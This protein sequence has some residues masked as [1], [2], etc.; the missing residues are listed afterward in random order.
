MDCAVR[1][2]SIV[3]KV[4][5]CIATFLLSATLSGAALL[6]N[7]TFSYSDGPLVS[8]T[9]SL[10]T[11]Y[12]GTTGQVKVV[13]G[14][15]F[16][17]KAN[18][19]DVH[20]ALAGQPYAST[21]GAILYVSFKI[22]YTNLPSSAGSYFAEFKDDSLGFRARI[23]AQTAGAASG[24]FR[25][26]IANAGSS[27]SAVF[28]ADLQTNTDYTIVARLAVSNVVS[29]LWL[30][31]TAETNA[32]VTATDAT[33]ALTIT[34]FGFREDGSSGTIGNFFVDDLRVGT[35]FPDVVTN[36]PPLERPDIVSSSQNQ[37]VTNGA[38]VTFSVSASGTPPLAYQWQFTPTSDVGA[39]GTNLPGAT[40]SNLTLTAVTFAQAGFYTVVITNV[41][42]FAGSDPV[43][44]SVWFVSPPSFSFLTYNANG[45]GQTNWSTNMWHVRAIG[46]QV[47]YLDPDIITFQEIPVT[48]N[49]TAQMVDF[50][51]AFCPGFY[52]VTNSADDGYIR[53]AILSR[54][55][56]VASKSWLHG[57]YL[58]PY[59]YT[60]ASPSPYFSRDLFEAQIAVP[61][62][63]QPLHVFTV[64]LKSGQAGPESSKRAAEAGAVSNFFATIYLPTNGLQPYVL[65][66]DLN[67]DILWPPDSNPQSI[68]RLVSAPTGL[69]LATPVNPF[70]DSELTISIRDDNGLTKRYDY[71]LPCAMLFSNIVG[72]QVFRT[73]L[74][75]PVPPNLY[76]DDE[77]ASDHLPVFMV[78]ANPFNV[79]FRLLSIG[80]TN[81]VVSLK[82]ESTSNRQYHVEVSSNLTAWTLLVTNL[83]ATGADFTFSTNVPSDVKFFRV[84]RAP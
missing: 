14:R 28:N 79:P 66:G 41:L 37:T 58:G 20:A 51:A 30:N 16:L 53:S 33:S 50:V 21:S 31:P 83:A 82:W 17:S 1:F 2:I 65:S 40:S 22:N 19:E 44:L 4:V 55:P 23:F 74:L 39:Q 71:I 68:Q 78:F 75:Y 72:S 45:N 52:L 60:N 77:N 46:R 32:G 38:S 6:L 59:G 27:P 62:F 12:S 18:T 76:S 49:C 63:P 34:S 48:N 43:V 9:D 24:A 56:I 29:T 10:W 11:T 25:I 8:A 36:A 61:G 47:Q 7:D 70:T 42:G 84:R 67:E 54:F 73:D 5:F 80:V 35:T 15:I 57:V 13:S 81:Q 26:G 64:H 69:Q 3:K